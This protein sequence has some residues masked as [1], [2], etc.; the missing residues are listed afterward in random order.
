MM[1]EFT[2]PLEQ[3]IDAQSSQDLLDAS[4]EVNISSFVEHSSHGDPED[5]VLIREEQIPDFLLFRTSTTGREVILL[6]E[7]KPERGGNGP[8]LPALMS[9]T[10]EQVATQVK[11]I[12]EKFKSQTTVY[13]L[14]VVGTA[15]CSLAFEKT[16]LSAL[17]QFSLKHTPDS[18]RMPYNPGKKHPRK[19]KGDVREIHQVFSGDGRDFK[20][21]DEFKECINMAMHSQNVPINIAQWER[22]GMHSN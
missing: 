13:A 5:E 4:M 18:G 21:S 11:F 15:F 2:D 20:F 16:K 14:L 3:V 19:K 10:Y 7:I 12:F 8:F 17:P 9:R 1:D 6:V 22:Q